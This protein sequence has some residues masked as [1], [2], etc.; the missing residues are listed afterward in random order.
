MLA[1]KIIEGISTLT[2]PL[3]EAAGSAAPTIVTIG[4]FD[5]VHLGHRKL[6]ERVIAA[7]RTHAARSVV[8]TFDPHPVQVLFPERKLKRL[9]PREDQCDQLR[10]MGV[11]ALVIEPFSRQLSQTAPA[12][13]LKN[14]IFEPL[15]PRGLIV[16]YD[17]SFGA[18]RQGGVAQIEEITRKRKLLL[19]IVPAFE[20]AGGVV[21]STR[22]RQ[23]IAAGD[24]GLAR[25]LLG[26][27]FYVQGLVEKGNQRGRRLGF[28]TANLTV[29]NECLPSIGVYATWTW[30]RGKR[31]QSATNVGRNPTFQDDGPVSVESYILRFDDYIYGEAVRVEF[32][33]RLRAEKKFSSVDEL[34]AQ[35]TLDVESARK[36]LGRDGA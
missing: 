17:F 12:E 8:F 19:E 18:N 11:D 14:Y 22:I 15:N 2:G 1:V 25:E 33:E 36:I 21:S 23:T 13:F 28:P 34:K 10:E 26:R 4:N 24:M 6:I 5:G 7:S 9:F 20:A 16:G 35:M 30:V 29:Q 3:F 32:A 31:Y 27:P